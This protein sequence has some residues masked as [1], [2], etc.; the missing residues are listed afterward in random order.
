MGI[1]FHHRAERQVGDLSVIGNIY[2]GNQVA[3]A[4]QGTHLLYPF[5]SGGMDD[6]L[7]F[8][9][10]QPFASLQA[11]FQIFLPPGDGGKVKPPGMG[12]FRVS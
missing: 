3:E 10:I 7:F 6:H 4:E 9:P 1:G 12:G 8:S 11:F 5:F 2:V